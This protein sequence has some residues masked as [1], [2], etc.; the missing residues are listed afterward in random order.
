[1]GTGSAAI[2][3]ECGVLIDVLRS[4]SR[5]E[6][7]SCTI[8]SSCRIISF[9]LTVHD[10]HDVEKAMQLV[11][12]DSRIGCKRVRLLG[13]GLVA[14]DFPKCRCIEQGELENH[15]TISR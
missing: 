13:R 1:M 10:E 14:E 12:G 11:K 9:V 8:L 2:G 3:A 6:N 7:S 5:S 15:R 4:L